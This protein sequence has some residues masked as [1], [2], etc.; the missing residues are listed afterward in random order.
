V[1]EAIEGRYGT[2]RTDEQLYRAAFVPLLALVPAGPQ[3]GMGRKA[4]EIAKR[5]RSCRITAPRRLRA[6][7]PGSRPRSAGQVLDEFGFVVVNVKQRRQAGQV[8]GAGDLS[9]GRDPGQVQLTVDA[10]MPVSGIDEQ[11]EAVGRQEC[12]RGQVE[13][14]VAWAGSGLV[15]QVGTQLRSSGHVQFTGYRDDDHVVL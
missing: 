14:D 7:L 4:L 13:H 12:H 15:H 8:E 6:S 11:A 10:P 1:P 5:S 9:V 2:E 3:L